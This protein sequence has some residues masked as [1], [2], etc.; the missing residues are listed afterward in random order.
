M[1]N[2]SLEFWIGTGVAV[3]LAILAFAVGVGMDAR[4]KGEYWFVV[5]CF[6]LSWLA[7]VAT[8]GLWYF[9]A[10]TPLF[11]RAIV[12]GLFIVIV[13]V[14]AFAAIGWATDRHERAT[15]KP[16]EQ[17]TV[18]V[19]DELQPFRIGFASSVFSSSSA[20]G[21][22]FW[23]TFGNGQ[24]MAKAPLSAIEGITVFNAQPKASVINQLTVE[25]ITD[26]G[27]WIKCARIDS[28]SISLFYVSN[29]DFKH[30][31]SIKMDMLDALIM[32]RALSPSETVSGYLLLVYP[33]SE[34]AKTF[35]GRF[36]ITI[37]DTGGA[38]YAQ[39]VDRTDAGDFG[40]M[41][42]T[43]DG[44]FDISGFPILSYQDNRNYWY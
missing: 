1:P 18:P 17:A 24:T 19:A 10:T 3:L 34:Q 32:N 29:D 41:S 43:G 44:R 11:K 20:T 16:Q 36:R 40:S 22:G 27:E 31:H 4:T 9:N 26:K 21:N 8:I 35:T 33:R 30:A 23:V 7:I 25:G 38:K 42:I 37:G 6:C 28:L 2:L 12:S 14:S 13:S 39:E 5:V 15:V